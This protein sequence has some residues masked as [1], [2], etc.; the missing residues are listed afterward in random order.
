[1]VISPD[2]LL[3]KNSKYV[4]I[5]ARPRAEYTKS[6]IPFAISFSWEDYTKTDERSIPYRM[7]PP[8]EMA[9]VLG[10]FGIDVNTPVAIYGDA[11]TSWGGE[12]W[13][14]W[15]LSYLGHK[16]PIRIL[17]GGFQAWTK[18]GAP[19]SQ[20]I[21]PLRR[22]SVTYRFHTD[23]SILIT[24][25]ELKARSGQLQIVDTRSF[26]ERLKSSIPGSVHIA[27]T[28]FYSGPNRRPLSGPD[29]ALLLRKN[30]I[31]P[32]K[33]VV[34]YCTGGIRSAYAWTVH[35]LGRLGPAINYEEGMVGWAPRN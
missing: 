35:R 23:P 31:D 25:T 34:Y 22:P 11:D 1:M 10:R 30:K 26:I 4:I 20:G 3:S 19:V 21:E 14:C 16:G 9:G 8:S 29:L 28:D 17:D 33:P 15:I 27:W 6:H 18:T 12:G 5:D 13:V 32:A 7:F 2:G 24:T